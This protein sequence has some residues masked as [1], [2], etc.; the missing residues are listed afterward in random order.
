MVESKEMVMSFLICK[1][2]FPLIF[3]MRT[4]EFSVVWKANLEA[5]PTHSS[6]ENKSSQNFAPWTYGILYSVKILDIFPIDSWT[7]NEHREVNGG[8]SHLPSIATGQIWR[9]LDQRWR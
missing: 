9:M 3:P 5:P 7:H 6:M 8:S 2:A 1:A 4:T